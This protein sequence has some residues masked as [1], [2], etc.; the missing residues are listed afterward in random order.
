MQEKL[1][2]VA[3]KTGSA[4]ASDAKDADAESAGFQCR[5]PAQG[6]RCAPTGS[7]AGFAHAVRRAPI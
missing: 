6:V 7:A 2:E 3:T 5:A 4:L 1:K